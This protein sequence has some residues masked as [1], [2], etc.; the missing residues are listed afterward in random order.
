MTAQPLT[1]D[2]ILAEL[3]ERKPE[4]SRRYDPSPTET[5]GP[6]VTS[7]SSSN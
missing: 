7:T 6:T 2:T 1:R 3:R 4:L 5:P